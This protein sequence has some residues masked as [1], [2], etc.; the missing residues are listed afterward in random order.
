MLYTDGIHLITDE[1][2]MN[3]LH[4]FA[5]SIGVKRCWFHNPRGKNKPHYDLTKPELIEKAIENGVKLVSSKEIV[6]ILKDRLSK[7]N[8]K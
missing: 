3:E 7:K 2:S 8:F 4:E 6:L 1:V 5:E